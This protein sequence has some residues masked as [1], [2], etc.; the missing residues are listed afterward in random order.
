MVVKRCDA[1]VTSGLLQLMAI[2]VLGVRVPHCLPVCIDWCPADV[3]PLPSC[4]HAVEPS[5]T[6]CSASTAAAY[7]VAAVGAGLAL[8]SG[9]VGVAMSRDP[10]GNDDDEPLLDGVAADMATSH[11]ADGHVTQ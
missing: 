1:G 6:L 4:S 3:Q 5:A 9:L 8:T 7:V 10:N 2:I 11:P